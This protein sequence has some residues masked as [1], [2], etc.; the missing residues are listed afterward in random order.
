MVVVFVCTVYV[1]DVVVM[2]F[3]VVFEVVA[4]VNFSLFSYLSSSLFDD[5][6]ILDVVADV[7]SQSTVLN[8]VF[9]SLLASSQFIDLLRSSRKSLWI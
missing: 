4:F 8:G 3:V 1:V 5:F 9:I 6:V 7:N 2:V